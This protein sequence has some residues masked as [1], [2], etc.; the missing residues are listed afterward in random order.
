MKFADYSPP[1]EPTL[2][3]QED[4]LRKGLGRAMQWARSGRLDRKFVL[5]ACLNDLR[6]DWQMDEPRGEWL[7]PIIEA[8]GAARQLRVPILHALHAAPEG[9]CGAQLC[10][11][12]RKYAETG[13]AA[14]RS[15]LYEIV[16][17]KPFVYQPWI[18]EEDLIVLEGEAGF[19]FAVAVRGRGLAQRG[20][21]SD[22]GMLV[23][24]A[25]KSVGAERVQEILRS[26]ANAFVQRF[27]EAWCRN[28]EAQSHVKKSGAR[29]EELEATPVASV[30]VAA[31][32]KNA[33]GYLRSWGRNASQEALCE[34][35]QHLWAERDTRLLAE[36]L[37]VFS[38]RPLPEFDSRLI[39]LGRHEDSGVRERAIVALGQNSHPAVRE[40]A[41]GEA[42]KGL[43]DGDVVALFA[44]NWQRFDERRI[45]ECLDPPDELDALHWLLR[46]TSD[47]LKENADSD[48]S[49]LGVICYALTPCAACRHSAAKVLVERRA[50]PAWLTA[51]CCDDAE[52]DTRA[53]G[54]KE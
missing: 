11:L 23:D 10:Q 46:E 45:L 33:R 47:T 22:D 9:D 32:Q 2:Q 36:L 5:Q 30:I 52:A 35:V 25:V 18:G 17:R 21:E 7:W 41:L 3:Q 26:S 16:E 28:R 44:K 50:A 4:A 31:G 48:P 15:V 37:R 51:E 6:F 34:F 43:R 14:F 39:D 38:A 40:F 24:H 29:A 19:L 1:S 12:A 49:Q 53:F 20:W 27:R 42:A 54:A 8:L 13:D